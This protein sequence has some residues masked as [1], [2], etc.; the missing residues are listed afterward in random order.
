MGVATAAQAQIGAGT[1]LLGG[2]AGY[3]Q[4]T[5]EAPITSS[6]TSQELVRKNMSVSVAPVLGYFVADNLMLGLRGGFQQTRTVTPLYAV[7]VNSGTMTYRKIRDNVARE[8]SWTVGPAARYYK[9]VGEQAAFY[10]ELGAG[11][12]QAETEQPNNQ[13]TGSIEAEA[14]GFYGGLAP[15][16]VFFPTPSIGLELS[17]RGLLYQQTKTN[18][19]GSDYISTAKNFDAGVSFQDLRLGV[20]F[21]LGRK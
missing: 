2:H 13:S 9:F 3:S 4:S 17:L 21:Y 6:S 18:N 20:S 19:K 8:A 16:L 11:Y 12:V 7:S 10:G 1:L 5:Q 15:G 14:K